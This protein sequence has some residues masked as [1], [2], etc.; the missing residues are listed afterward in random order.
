M[1]YEV[2]PVNTC[3]RYIRITPVCFKKKD[4]SPPQIGSISN[5]YKS[6]MMI[7]P[8]L[9]LT[10]LFILLTLNSFI[11]SEPTTSASLAARNAS[12]HT[13]V[14]ARKFL[15]RRRRS[16]L[17]PDSL[18]R[19]LEAPLLQVADF[20]HAVK[21]IKRRP[22]A[23]GVN[24]I[25]IKLRQPDELP[26]FIPGISPEPPKSPARNETSRHAAG[27]LQERRFRQYILHI[28][29]NTHTTKVSLWNT[30]V[31]LSVG[32]PPVIDW[33]TLEEAPGIQFAVRPAITDILSKLHFHDMKSICSHLLHRGFDI[34]SI[35]KDVPL[36]GVDGIEYPAEFAGEVS[37]NR[38]KRNYEIF[39]S[40]LCSIASRDSC[41]IQ[42][43]FWI[44]RYFSEV[45]AR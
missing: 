2:V 22:L 19:R 33:R 25:P 36:R 23:G 4:L 21:L 27:V 32:K 24:S 44:E 13:L 1:E 28:A 5:W 8:S 10:A 43:Y 45:K 41:F 16:R 31:K 9:R 7:F 15:E 40:E 11:S 14:Q 30:V 6:N 18:N 38:Q 12:P 39:L 29:M 35:L 26:D 34:P 3:T 17:F 20:G 42:V 37:L